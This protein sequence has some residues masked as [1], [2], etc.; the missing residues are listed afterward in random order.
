MTAEKSD[1]GNTKLES[2][3]KQALRKFQKPA[4][5]PAPIFDSRDDALQRARTSSL[6]NIFHRPVI[7]SQKHKEN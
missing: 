5:E 2:T 7:A 3:D 1:E 4:F 6:W